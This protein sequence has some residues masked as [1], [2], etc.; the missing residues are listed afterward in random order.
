VGDEFRPADLA[1]AQRRQVPG[2]LL[3]IDHAHFVGAAKGNQSYQRDLG[4]ISL[5]GKHR[6]AKDHAAQVHAVEAAHQFTVYPGLHAV[7]MARPVKAAVSV[8]HI[9]NNPGARLAG[10]RLAGTGVDDSFKGAVET[11]FAAGLRLEVGEGFSQRA[12]QFEMPVSEEPCADPGS[13]I[14]AAGPG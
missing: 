13:T 7:G 8:H 4:G 10:A 1:R 6:L 3:A 11:D 5:V 9:G 14:T 2:V 12:M